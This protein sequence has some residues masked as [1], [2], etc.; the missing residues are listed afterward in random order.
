MYTSK[1]LSTNTR[2]SGILETLVEELEELLDRRQ[3]EV[4]NGAYEQFGLVPRGV[5]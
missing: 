3:G 1:V 5:W 4:R 2:M